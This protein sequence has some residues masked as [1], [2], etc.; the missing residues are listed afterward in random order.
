M[1]ELQM[2]SSLV[3]LDVAGLILSMVFGMVYK[4]TYI[5]FADIK[6]IIT[7]TYYDRLYYFF[8]CPYLTDDVDKG[9]NAALMA[10]EVANAVPGIFSFI[11]YEKADVWS[12]GAMAYEIFGMS[13]MASHIQG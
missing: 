13:I 10:P 7:G 9:G 1:T 2:K 12:C 3:I 5:H 8:S 4:I 6:Y 11:N